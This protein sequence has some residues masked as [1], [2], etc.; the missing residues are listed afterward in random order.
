MPYV[1]TIDSDAP[2]RISLAPSVI[3]GDVSV[4]SAAAVCGDATVAAARAE[5]SEAAAGIGR[6]FGGTDADWDTPGRVFGITDTG[7]AQTP[8]SGGASGGVGRVFGGT[9]ADWDAPGRVFGGG[10]AGGDSVSGDGGGVGRVFGGTDADWNA[11]GRVF[12][13]GNVTGVA[14]EIGGVVIDE[15]Y[16]L[17]AREVAQLKVARDMELVNER[18]MLQRRDLAA[19]EMNVE[20]MVQAAEQAADQAADRLVEALTGEEAARE[21]VE[22]ATTSLQTAKRSTKAM[23]D[24]KNREKARINR[25]DVGTKRNERQFSKT[26]A[27]QSQVGCDADAIV[28]SA[29]A[30]RDAAFNVKRNMM[31]GGEHL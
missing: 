16:G 5:P 9:D 29:R 21:E 17:S 30:K 15:N 8:V 1:I 6:V 22:R 27:S 3:T 24:R 13:N 28:N 19:L 18:A 10:I 25:G 31:E 4:S 11:P 20:D 2:P 23:I 7:W 12:G 14:L 26:A